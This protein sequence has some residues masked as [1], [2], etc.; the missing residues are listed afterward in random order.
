MG[1]PRNIPHIR[2]VKFNVTSKERYERFI[3]IVKMIIIEDI[4]REMEEERKQK[5]FNDVHNETQG[6]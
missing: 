3:E 6:D 2:E 5:N 1:K 4:K